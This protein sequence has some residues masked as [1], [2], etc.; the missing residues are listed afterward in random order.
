M[1]SQPAILIG[2]R[3]AG[4]EGI[5]EAAPGGED[6]VGGDGSDVLEESCT[7]TFRLAGLLPEGFQAVVSGTEGEGQ[8]IHGRED[9]GQIFLPVSE[10]VRQVNGGQRTL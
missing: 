5:H 7:R 6:E 1:R 8:W 3:I 10:V 2:R 9:L 4:D